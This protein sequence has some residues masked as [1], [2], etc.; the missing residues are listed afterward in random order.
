MGRAFL[1]S[2]HIC[3]YKKEVHIGISGNETAEKERLLEMIRKG[4][5]GEDMQTF[6]LHHPES[7]ITA[8][9]AIFAC[10]QCGNIEE[11]MRICLKDADAS[12][13]YRNYCTNCRGRMAHVHDASNVHCPNC[14]SPMAISQSSSW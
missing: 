12:F 10:T 2:C 7:E 3:S 5:Y 6:I 14:K 4:A 1:L 8:F 13:V 11:R 9:Q